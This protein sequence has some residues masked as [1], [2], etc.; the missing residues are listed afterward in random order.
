MA[1]AKLLAF[2]HQ[3]FSEDKQV[4][5]RKAKAD[6]PSRVRTQRLGH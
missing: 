6:C 2:Y 4:A 3:L 5:I 1:V